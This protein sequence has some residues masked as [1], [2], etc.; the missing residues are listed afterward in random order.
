MGET[1]GRHFVHVAFGALNGAF[2]GAAR[3]RQAGANPASFPRYGGA[4]G[5]YTCGQAGRRVWR[6]L[7]ILA[8]VVGG[9]GGIAVALLQTPPAKRFILGK[10][11]T[12]LATQDIVFSTDGFNYNL[13]N[14]SDRAAQRSGGCRRGCLTA[15]RFWRSPTRSSI[16]SSWQVLRGRYVVQGANASGVRLHFANEQGIDNLP[17][18]ASDPD[19]PRKPVDYLDHQSASSRRRHSASA[20][21]ARSRST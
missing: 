11:T 6:R 4:V 10:V 20:R 17:R 18:P 7:A 2:Q 21:T 16:W 1:D 19:Q 8:A 13:L 15:P 5:T 12:L 9:L 3:R 14:L